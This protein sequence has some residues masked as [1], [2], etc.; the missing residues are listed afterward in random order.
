M[1]RNRIRLKDLELVRHLAR[2]GTITGAAA[3]ANVSQPAASQRLTS[4]QDRVGSTLF[5]R[6]G[7]VMR[8]TQEGKRL[9]DAA[10]NIQHQ[11]DRVNED[12][13]TSWQQRTRQL[14]VATQCYTLYRW[15]P[16]VIRDLLNQYPELEVDV[17]PEATDRAPD[18]ILSDELDVA[19][20]NEATGQF[21][22]GR[23]LF[24]DEMFA[25]MCPTHPMAGARWLEAEQFAD[26]S[27]LLYTGEKHA[28]VEE[29]LKPAGVPTPNIIQIRI[30]EAIIELAR[31]GKG[32]AILAGWALHDL[33][34]AAD[35][36]P[37]R[38]TRHGFARQWCGITN[39]AAPSD[40]VDAFLENVRRIGSQLNQ[41]GWRTKLA[42][43]ESA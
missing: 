5:I 18:A 26:E 20:V 25:V 17:V 7:G 23:R 9:L 3:R 34:D 39:P 37:V 24:E 38:I 16:L 28:I 19:L 40:Q 15:L 2:A 32:I 10:I 43:A 13:L 35:L 31:A 4:L 8:P 11:L 14:R 33:P 42:A 1:S 27:L 29:V 6:S 41:P 21:S 30:T 22:Q 12:L 36:V